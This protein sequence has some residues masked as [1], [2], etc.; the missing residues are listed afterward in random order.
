MAPLPLQ[1]L[2]QRVFSYVI[3]LAESFVGDSRSQ[4]G[5]EALLSTKNTFNGKCDVRS[6]QFIM[7]C[8]IFFL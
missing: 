8:L 1:A 2:P 6:D 3:Y 5:N 4:V 7:N